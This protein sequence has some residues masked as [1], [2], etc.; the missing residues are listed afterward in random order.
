MNKI[1]KKFLSIII[2]FLFFYFGLAINGVDDYAK[3]DCSCMSDSDCIDAGGYDSLDHSKCGVTDC[4]LVS[5]GYLCCC[6]PDSNVGSWQFI[7]FGQKGIP[8]ELNIMGLT[9]AT[10]QLKDIIRT[11]L[12]IAISLLGVS[13]I[14]VNLYGGF[15][16]ITAGDNEEQLVK[17]KKVFTSGWIGIGIATGFIIV[18]AFLGY[19]FGVN[20]LDFSGLE[21]LL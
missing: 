19:V 12:L 16:W 3:T 1:V 13:A 18:L 14:G 20:I 4:D 5:S 17:A 8:D 11:V 10:S 15:L 21:Q 7:L 9:L 2:F 6:I